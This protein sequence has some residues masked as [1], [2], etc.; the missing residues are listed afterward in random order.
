LAGDVQAVL[1]DGRVSFQNQEVAF[2]IADRPL[3]RR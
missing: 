3:H 1:A 2:V